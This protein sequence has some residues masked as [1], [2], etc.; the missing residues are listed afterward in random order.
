MPL[1]RLVIDLRGSG[2]EEYLANKIDS[3]V[4]E[5]LLTD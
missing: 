4:G 5:L 2:R 3:V 1:M